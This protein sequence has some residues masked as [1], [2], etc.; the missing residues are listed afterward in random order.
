MTIGVLVTHSSW[1]RVLPGPVQ[2]R[3]AT[4]GSKRRGK[5]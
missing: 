3:L 4:A 2:R 1:G 5:L